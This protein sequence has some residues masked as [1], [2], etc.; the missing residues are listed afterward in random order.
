MPVIRSSFRFALTLGAVTVALAC[1]N[2]VDSL[3]E[4]SLSKSG[5][6]TTT[7]TVTA[8]Q[9][10]AAQRDTT[11]DVQV[12]GGGF[13][14]GS[15]ASFQLQGV[16]DPRVH[17]NSTRFVAS[18]QLVAN[19]TI[20][21]DAITAKYD[22][23]VT[24][25]GGKKGVGSELFTVTLQAEALAGG[26][27]AYSANA[28]GVAVGVGPSVNCPAGI[29]VPMLWQA[30]GTPMQLPLAGAC[31]GA[32]YAINSSGK[33]LGEISFST[34]SSM[35][36]LWT[37][38]GSGYIITQLGA[39]PDGVIP[40]TLGALNDSGQVVGFGT[41]IRMYWWSSATGWVAMPSPVD[42]TLC[43][44]SFFA[45]NNPGAIVASCLIG[46]KATSRNAYYWSNYAAIPVLLPQ[47]PGAANMS[48]Y[49]I[50]DSAV[51]VGGQVR[52]TPTASGYVATLLPDL[53]FGAGATQISADGTIAGY[54]E[55]N[56]VGSASVAVI[57]PPSGGLITGESLLDGIWSQAKGIANTAGGLVVV[58]TQGT[59]RRAVL[60]RPRSP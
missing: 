44:H 18:T 23:V 38:S 60:W 40:S 14:S 52:W 13:D 46:K 42:A 35:P 12:I 50:N 22:A 24:T 9:P 26:T 54:V 2:R 6:V 57:W 17:V 32:A 59:T 45:I 28:T 3:L 8:T 20:A 31:A 56:S 5:S 48:P 34:S 25:A 21:P 1:S 11:L 47:V 15:Q 16:L 30:D 4:P 10:V 37:P 41:G 7:V 29:D 27:I 51:I 58:G 55:T 49:A 33:V 19:V 43:Y 53:G 39:A 36:V